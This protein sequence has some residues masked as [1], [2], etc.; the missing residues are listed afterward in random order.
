MHLTE[1]QSLLLF[2]LVQFSHIGGSIFQ[3]RWLSRS[4]IPIVLLSLLHPWNLFFR[5]LFSGEG[6]TGKA[7]FICNSLEFDTVEIRI[8][9]MF[10]YSEK[11]YSKTGMH[12]VLNNKSWVIRIFVFGNI[13]QRDIILLLS[14]YSTAKTFVMILLESILIVII[15]LTKCLFITILP[16]G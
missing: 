11:L 12:P 16:R 6:K 9:Q 7:G 5:P 1:H 8:V 10:P 2:R 4:E 3:E 15:L 13:S 14:G